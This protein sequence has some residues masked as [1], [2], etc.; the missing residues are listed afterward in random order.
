MDYLMTIRRARNILFKAFLI[1]AFVTIICWAFL[2]FDLTQY[3][4][5][6]LPEFGPAGANVFI[7]ILVGL[8]DIAGLIFFLIPSLALSW[9]I[10]CEKKRIV[11]EEK[12][13]EEFEERVYREL[14]AEFGPKPKKRKK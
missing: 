7:L 4:M 2:M 3:F 14:D 6:A 12:E 11:R 8:I 9:E 13:F 10:I 1:A 5:W